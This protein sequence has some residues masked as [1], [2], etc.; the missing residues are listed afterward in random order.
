MGNMKYIALNIIVATKL[1]SHIPGIGKYDNTVDTAANK[2]EIKKT[3]IVA[4][5]ALLSIR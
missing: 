4:C 3:I 1:S 2:A 5:L